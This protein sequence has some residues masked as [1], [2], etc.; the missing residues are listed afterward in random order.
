MKSLFNTFAVASLIWLAGFSG[1]AMAAPAG[2]AENGD[3]ACVM[4]H[5]TDTVNAIK[6]TKHYD[7]SNSKSPA[8][9]HGCESCH[10]PSAEHAASPMT[11]K[12]VRFGTGSDTPAE[13]QLETCTSCHDSEPW[14]ASHTAFLAMPGVTCSNCHE[15]H[16]AN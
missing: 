9:N 2:Y 15:V 5:N 14:K 11:V 4:C 6:K 12:N 7:K 16:K 8:A 13:K 1:S 3:Q 10:G